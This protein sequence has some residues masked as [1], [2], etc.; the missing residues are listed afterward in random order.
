MMNNFLAHLKNIYRDSEKYRIF[1][2][3]FDIEPT[4]KSVA[5]YRERASQ[6]CIR[7]ASH[8]CLAF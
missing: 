2:R 4:I 7:D 8:P 5:N 6:I 3:N 1:G